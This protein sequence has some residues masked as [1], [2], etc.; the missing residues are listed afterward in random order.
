MYKSGCIVTLPPPTPNGGLHVGHLGG[1]FLAADVFTR[2]A[3]LQGTEVYVTSYSDLN[4]SYVRVT[5]ERQGQDP[6]ALA[7]AMTTDI[8]ET[9]G[10]YDVSIDAMEVPGGDMSAATRDRV[11]Q[12]YEQGQLIRK[13][14]SF[15]YSAERDM[16]LDEA[17]VSGFCPTCLGKCKCGICEGCA[18]I[19]T[20]DSLIDPKDTVTGSRALEKRMV[21]VLV[22]EIERFRRSIAAFHAAN[23]LVRTR[24]RWLAED[25]LAAPLPDFPVS[26]PG[27]WGIKLD[28]SDFPGQVVNAWAEVA[29]NLLYCYEQ[30]DFSNL[31]GDRPKIVNFYGFDNTYFYA[32]VHIALL[33]AANEQNRL[34]D[35]ALINEFYNLDYKKFSTSNN[36]VIWAR[37]LAR[38]YHPDLIRFF[39]ALTGPGF[40]KANFNEVE[41]GRLMQD[42]FVSRWQ[43]TAIAYNALLASGGATTTVEPAWAAAGHQSID[44]IH[45]SYTAPRF[46]LR[47]AAE[48][49]L[50]LLELVLDQAEQDLPDDAAR[51]NRIGFLL[52]CFAIALYPIMPQVGQMLYVHLSDEALRVMHP[53][54]AHPLS[55]RPLPEFLFGAADE[56]IRTEVPA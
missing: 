4:Q 52:R 17:G 10:V 7:L 50:N 19:N 6:T 11:V 9:L 14:M 36:H 42:I 15:F 34:P 47:Q 25:A 55:R 3:R 37:D 31:Q 27:D 56:P 53:D 51:L 46:H 38:R 24:Y 18:R 23:P 29:L 43:R 32:I 12:L 20:P 1:P 33:C 41:M 35:A 48:D 40:E 26:L 39:T 30:A 5:A 44:R 45:A 13:E 28:H 8:V 22:L 16:L 21:T 2:A 54:P 49:I